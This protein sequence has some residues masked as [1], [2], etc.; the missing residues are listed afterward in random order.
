VKQ[1]LLLLLKGMAMGGADIIP[2]V[3]GGTIAFITGIYEELIHSIKSVD[4]NAI[5]LLFSFRFKEFWEKVNGPFLITLVLGILISAFSLVQLLSH[6]L[7]NYPIQ[8]WSFFFGLILVSAILVARQVRTWS[9]KEVVA[10][11]IGIIVAFLITQ[12]TASETPDDLWFIYICGAIAICAMILPGISGS[13]ILVLLG[14]YEYIINAIKDFNIGVLVV[15]ALGCITG[16]AAF[17]RLVSWLLARYHSMTISLLAGFMLGS[18]N[19]IWP[20]KEVQSENNILPNVYQSQGTDP[21]LAEALLFFA[22][23]VLLVILIEKLA[24]SLKET[25]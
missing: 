11:L 16:I 9:V 21:Y 19:K 22:V 23:G 5:A 8:L 18:L 1:R 24:H 15:F 7:E 6:L 2:G 13:F 10:G 4:A 20:W 17:S 25:K 3:S 12:G 14:K